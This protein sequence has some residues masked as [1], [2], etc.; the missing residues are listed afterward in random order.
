MWTHILR[1]AAK[2][3]AVDQHIIGN[4][5]GTCSYHFSLLPQLFGG[6]AL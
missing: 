6:K 1:W 3:I 4:E 5:F 2:T